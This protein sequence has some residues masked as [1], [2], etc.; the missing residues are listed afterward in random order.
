M[1]ARQTLLGQAISPSPKTRSLRVSRATPWQHGTVQ[2]TSKGGSH[3]LPPILSVHTESFVLFFQQ[4]I[5]VY[6][7][8]SGQPHRW[9]TLA[10][11]HPAGPLSILS[12]LSPGLPMPETP[13]RRNV[14]VHCRR[15]LLSYGG[16]GSWLTR[17]RKRGQMFLSSTASLPRE[18][19]ERRQESES[20]S[21][22]TPAGQRAILPTVAL[23]V[24]W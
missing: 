1:F 2:P 15:R 23:A 3:S 5:I 22:I 10:S 12:P 16:G 24:L 17:G 8:P 18:R 13:G 19:R 11:S 7:L 9:A 20:T 4:R 6:A 21:C 14:V